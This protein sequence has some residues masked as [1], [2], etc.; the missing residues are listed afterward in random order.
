MHVSWRI[1]PV[2]ALAPSDRSNVQWFKKLGSR[3]LES[4][5]SVFVLSTIYVVN[6]ILVLG[7]K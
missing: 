7:R 1:V 3:G 6:L 2:R 4:H 5:F